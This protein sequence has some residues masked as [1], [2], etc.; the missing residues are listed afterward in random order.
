[1][2]YISKTHCESDRQIDAG[3]Q[4]DTS[5][6]WSQ[7][8]SLQTISRNVGYFMFSWRQDVSF[9]LLKHLEDEMT[10]YQSMQRYQAYHM[11]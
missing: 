5:S 6:V 2:Y 10:P 7:K 1:M 8:G 3:Q 11:G 4:L 9:V